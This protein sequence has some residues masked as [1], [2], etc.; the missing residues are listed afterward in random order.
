M[1][2]TKAEARWRR[3]K[4]I[5][6]RVAFAAGRLRL[7]VFRSTSHIY[8]QIVS[9]ESGNTLVS[10]ST[11]DSEVRDEVS[12]VS[13]ECSHSKAAS[14]KSVRAAHAVGM[15]LARR[16]KSKD[17]TRVV[18]DRNGFLYHGRVKALADGARSVGLDF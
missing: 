17:I 13:E 15:V 4:R 3:K 5:R 18:F 14:C 7:S 11:R 10:A 2:K 12:K 8:A 1:S 16:A 9:D 6:K